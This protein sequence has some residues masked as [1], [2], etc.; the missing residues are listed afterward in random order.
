M[1]C[2][3][4]DGVLASNVA[5]FDDEADLKHLRQEQRPVEAG[6]ENG[7]DQA[8]QRNPQE[9]AGDDTALEDPEQK[10]K[11]RKQDGEDHLDV[12]GGTDPDQ[13]RG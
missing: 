10:G 11:D 1:A 12:A 13:G 7:Q 8:Q 4:V 3:E 2:I 9:N 6:S 5:R